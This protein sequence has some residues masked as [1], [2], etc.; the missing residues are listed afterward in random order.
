MMMNPD[1]IQELPKLNYC[2]QGNKIFVKPGV[3]P[4]SSRKLE[5][6]M[7]IANLQ[8]YYQCN[9][10]RFI[11]DF[12]NIELL[13][14][15]AWVIQRAWNCPNVLLVCT[16]GFGKS[17]LIDI[18][19]MAKDMLF[20][21]YWT[22]I[23]SGSGSQAEQT[24]TT[25]E[26]LANDNIDTMLGSTGYIFKAEIEIKNAAGDGFSH[27]SNGFSYS[28]YNGSFTQTLNSNVDKKRGMRGSVVFD[29]CG[30]L[31]EE[32]MS[33]YAAFA[34]VNKSFKSGKD[35]DG[36]SIDRNRLRC[37]PSNIPNQL[38]YISSASS[39]DT[40]FYK[41]YRDF[42]KR[43]LMG[44]PD[45]FVAHI[46]CE[47]AFKPTIRGETMEPLLTPGTV[48]AEMR[49]NPEKA[50]RE[51]YCEFTSDAGA[52][53][54][55]RRG[56]IARN[57]VIRKPVLYND[58]GKRKIV[59]AYDPARSRDNSVI[60]VCEIYSE[61]N[62]DGDLEYKMRLLNCIN[63]IDI[64]NKKKKKPMQTPAQ[65][66]YLKQV[67]LDYN[68]GGD[69]NYS[70]IL[71]VYID[72]GSGGGGV[73]IADYLMPDWKDK[74]GKTHRGL[75]DKEYSEE[76]VKKFPNAVNKLHLMEPT[77]YKSEMYEAM[78]EMMNQDKIEFTATYDNKGYLTIFDIDKDKYE[79]TKK[80]L[81]AKY[82]KQKMTDEEIDYNVQK[83]LD[84]LQN[85]KS[86]IEKLNWQEEASL[87]SIDALKEELVN[88]IRIPR[89]SGKDSF[90]LCPEKAN[91]L[92]DD[93][94]YVT[95]MC[96]YALQTERRKNITEKRKSKV[97][98]SLVQKL[99]IR[100]GVVHSMFE[101]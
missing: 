3:Y 4:L 45:Y 6:F 17:T 21:N 88:M 8:K 49:S 20:N 76:Y 37:I 15:Q 86:H 87:S 84:K 22:Y 30:F 63:L 55:I 14:A 34:I 10:V 70:N 58:T 92:H 101:T 2:E 100:K 59:I 94:A 85:V 5:G 57:E 61:K 27:S 7:K 65:I 13:D 1:L 43:Q 19:I 78:I 38:F 75:I 56:V 36:K 82:K 99:T 12:F 53:A 25:L 74:S 97:D 26:R 95:C 96:S 51:Y 48:A 67:I 52:N 69:E 91:R 35:R 9:P 31:D 77:K 46:D 47:V 18:M 98:K 68:Q 90:E 66:E 28:L 83:E 71:G 54:I 93:R 33:V 60:L 81:I 50:R 64:S 24:F 89:Q 23:A 39:T 32:M 44:D 40:K 62:Q 16:R 11:N 41:L 72:A 79:K 73:N 29:E 80:D 42:S